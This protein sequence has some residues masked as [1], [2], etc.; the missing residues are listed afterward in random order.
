VLTFHCDISVG[1]TV[2]K[3]KTVKNSTSPVWNEHF[4]VFLLVLPRHF[5]TD[6]L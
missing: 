5:N 4:E 6:R 2:L 3:T 1:T